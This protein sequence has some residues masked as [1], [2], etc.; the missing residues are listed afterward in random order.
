MMNFKDTVFYCSLLFY[1]FSLGESGALMAPQG[2]G[3]LLRNHE[4]RHGSI[5][6]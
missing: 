3:G 6:Y 2:D 5:L 1:P 4:S